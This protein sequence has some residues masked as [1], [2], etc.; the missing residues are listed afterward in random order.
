[1][2]ADR[3]S[4]LAITSQ[5]PWPLN[6]GGHL[7]TFHLLRNLGKRFRVRL[8]AGAFEAHLEGVAAL[9][10]EGL[11]IRPVH[12]GPRRLWREGL[13]VLTAAVRGEPYVLYHRHNRGAVRAALRAEMQR[14]PPDLIYLDH[15]DSAVFFRRHPGVP[16]AIDLHNVYSLLVRREA[17]ERHGLTQH[18]L[19]REAQLLGR[20]EE[21]AVH[22]ADVVFSVSDL[23][24]V[25]FRAL[26]ARVVQVVPNG[27]DCAAYESL[28]TGRR[29]GTPVIL[30]VGTMS[31]TPNA[32]AARFLAAEVL[33]RVRERLPT[34]ELWVVGK[35]PPPDL[36]EMGSRPGVRVTGGVPAM[37]PFLRDAHALAVPLEVGGGTRLKILEAFAAGLPVVSTAVGCEGLHVAADEHLLVRERSDFADALASLLAK[38]AIGEAL[39]GR[40]RALVRQLY[41]WDAVGKL[42]GD[43]LENTIH[44]R[45]R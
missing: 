18:Y 7:R 13:Q 1:M 31:W 26:G 10:R 16:L 40:A 12:L 6:T 39:A 33:P 15:L 30:Y 34:A 4:V 45:P 17:E 11:S 23:E 3:P 41:D 43:A 21:R 14:E 44:A 29:D 20:A 35:E 36:V 8:I 9:E 42:A 22:L 19:Q 25:H 24:A 28:P 32:S 37:P 5:L 27:V 2:S 38:P